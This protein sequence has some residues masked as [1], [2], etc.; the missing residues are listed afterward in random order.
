MLFQRRHARNR[1][2][3]QVVRA[4]ADQQAAALLRPQH[5]ED[6]TG[7]RHRRDLQ[8]LAAAPGPEIEHRAAVER[9]R[10]QHRWQRR[11]IARVLV[12]GYQRIEKRIRVIGRGR[13]GVA[14]V[15]PADDVVRRTGQGDQRG[16]AAGV[17]PKGEVTLD[18]GVAAQRHAP[19]DD[20]QPS[21]EIL[22]LKQTQCRR[23]GLGQQA[24]PAQAADIQF[25]NTDLKRS[26][27]RRLA[28][29]RHRE[30]SQHRRDIARE[31]TLPLAHQ[32]R[33]DL[34][35]LGLAQRIGVDNH[36]AQ[37]LAAAAFR[38][39]AVACELS[40]QNI[41]CRAQRHHLIAAGKT[42]LRVVHRNAVDAGRTAF[43]RSMRI[44][45][46][47]RRGGAGDRTARKVIVAG[48]I[49]VLRAAEQHP[50]ALL[51]ADHP[52]YRAH[53]IE[54]ARPLQA[55]VDRRRVGGAEIHHGERTD[56][57]GQQHRRM[58]PALRRHNIVTRPV[59]ARVAPIDTAR[60]IRA[61][62][63]GHI[64]VNPER[65]ARHRIGGGRMRRELRRQ[66]VRRERALG[67]RQRAAEQ[68]RRFDR[69]R[70]G[71][72]FGQGAAAGDPAE[73]HR[74]IGVGN[75]HAALAAHREAGRARTRTA[76]S[77]QPLA[78][79]ID[80]DRLPLLL[81]QDAVIDQHFG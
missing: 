79:E 27:Q 17:R 24:G 68:L 65:G 14:R 30:R 48:G 55:L 32:I 29:L 78:H 41:A 26:G 37:P 40:S 46:E 67:Q 51:R 45:P 19:L 70:A 9:R 38:E 12:V 44:L 56:L 39:P 16:R 8:P 10:L 63:A 66:P 2:A 35:H 61:E 53:V 6:R 81:G 58:R 15:A 31:R 34:G 21:R 60:G 73:R 50:A 36:L 5:P 59:P 18:L 64:G 75:L 23:A 47:E 54:R 33:L 13:I 52:E 72:E 62:A 74:H 11:T 57:V 71:P 43:H 80:F 3:D 25:A 4:A 76:R 7:V 49:L 22:K 77:A 69:H 42:G 1:P 28:L 20:V